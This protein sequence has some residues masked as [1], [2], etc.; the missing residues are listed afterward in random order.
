MD[1]I[2]ID[3]FIFNKTNLNELG[4]KITFL[5]LKLLVKLNAY[6]LASLLLLKS[7][8]SA[9]IFS[10]SLYLFKILPG[11]LE[12]RY[13][14]DI[15]HSI[16]NLY[17]LDLVLMLLHFVRCRNKDYNEVNHFLEQQLFELEANISDD[18][19]KLLA[20]ECYN[21]A[22]FLLNAKFL[23]RKA[24]T[25]YIKAKRYNPDY[26][27]RP[28]FLNEIGGLLFDLERYSISSKIYEKS[29]S[30]EENNEILPM[31]A[32]ALLFS[33]EYQKSLNYFKIFFE[34]STTPGKE[35]W[36]L[37]YEVISSAFK[38]ISISSQKRNPQKAAS[39]FEDI[40]TISIDK[41]EEALNF[42]C[43]SN[44]AWYNLGI[45]HTEL[46]SKQF[47]FTMAAICC[48][49]D[50]IA[51]CNATMLAWNLMRKDSSFMGIFFLIIK[52]AYFF[53]KMEF[54]NQLKEEMHQNLISYPEYQ[55][56]YGKILNALTNL[57]LLKNIDEIEDIEDFKNILIDS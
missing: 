48:P 19:K 32:D 43:L 55:N 44:L 4:E 46:E 2:E 38:K 33:G 16:K 7:N 31:Y 28:Y 29:L 45:C 27:S 42:D 36:L 40:S 3:N 1:V 51:W 26:L 49:Q 25:Y 22:N 24:L 52:E 11:L 23:R 21:Y 34:K 47:C 20:C 50:I 8:F 17:S 15:L 53:N 5:M 41:C 9:S 14:N 13:I 39:L 57:C 56:E 54:I 12:S 6:N 37:K 10:N 30:L 35:K 18:T